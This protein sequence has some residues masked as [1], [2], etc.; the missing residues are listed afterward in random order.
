[1]SNE[2]KPKRTWALND[3]ELGKC[4]GKGKFGRVYLAREKQTHYIVALKILSKRQLLESRME[5][6]LRREIEIQSH[7][8][9]ENILR[10]YGYF[11]DNKRIYLIL[12]YTPNGEVFNELRE[13]HRFPEPKAANYI[14]QV[15][16]ALLYLHSKSVIHRD[17]KPE[18]LLNSCGVIKVSDFGWSIH[19]PS[20][21]RQTLCGTL[22]YLPPEMIC[23]QDYD[24]TVDN[25]ALGVLAYEFLVGAPPFEAREPRETYRRIEQV[26]FSLP[27]FVSQE[28]QDFI[29]RLIKRNPSERM[30]LEEAASHPWLIK[31]KHVT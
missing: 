26:K 19:C 17:I 21:R 7:M 20:S 24:F 22:D 1:M 30:T 29:Q 11:W 5:Q 27:D 16:N 14:Y 13:E 6:Q 2:P 28:A 10:L 25:W 31:F 9:H 18:N 3:F 8:H 23:K 12:E 15:T 4:L